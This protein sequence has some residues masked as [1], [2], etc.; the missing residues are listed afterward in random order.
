MRIYNYI[1]ACEN[2]SR[3]L[4]EA[5]KNKDVMI[6]SETGELFIVQLAHQKGSAYNLPNID[7]GL[8]RDEIVNYI[9]E[10]RER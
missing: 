8:S 5:K 3:L 4:D 10:T 1:D 6:E 9:K 7:L 2:L